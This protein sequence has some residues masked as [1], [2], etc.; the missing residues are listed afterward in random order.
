M[1][2]LISIG[3]S[4]QQPI[5][6]SG[7][8]CINPGKLGTF[9][10]VSVVLWVQMIFLCV[11]LVLNELNLEQGCRGSS[12]GSCRKMDVLKGEESM[13]VWSPWTTSD[14]LN[15]FKAGKNVLK[16][17][18]LVEFRSPWSKILYPGHLPFP[19]AVQRKKKQSSPSLSSSRRGSVEPFPVAN[20]GKWEMGIESSLLQSPC[21]ESDMPEE[22]Q[23][24]WRGMLSLGTHALHWQLFSFTQQIFLG[25]D[26]FV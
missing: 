18:I 2:S 22:H 16:R 13:A 23:H 5:T 11:F 25:L 1:I 14:S 7:N 19:P 24:F 26:I 9:S 3:L 20:K 15:L 4:L 8:C 17:R 10:G 12:Q 21:A 6:E